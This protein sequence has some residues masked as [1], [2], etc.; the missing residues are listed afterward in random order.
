MIIKNKDELS[1]TE[2]RRHALDIV[3]AGIKRVLPSKIMA[4]AVKFNKSKKTIII[5]DKSY[6]IS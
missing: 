5:N 3:E 2:L 1:I 4:H 6:G